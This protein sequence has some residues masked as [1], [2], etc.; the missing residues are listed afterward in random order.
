MEDCAMELRHLRYF[1]A[2][3]DTLHFT[4]A[5]A[6]LHIAQPA[7]SQQIRVLE[8]E[9]GVELFR[10]SSRHTEITDA[11]RVF[12]VEAKR[13]VAQ[14]DRSIEIARRAQRGEIG[15]IV[16]GFEG[17]A[18]YDLLPRI[19]SRFRA[20]YPAVR[21]VL[22]QQGTTE[23]IDALLSGRIDVGL[24]LPDTRSAALSTEVVSREP[25]IAALPL[26]Q[27]LA[28]TARIPISAL[29]TEEFVLFPRDTA[30]L[31]YDQII[32]MCAAAGFSPR[33]AQESVR[34]VTIIGLVAA[35]FGVSIVPRCVG[36][37]RH[38]QVVFRPFTEATP[39]LE[40]A[41]AWHPD[42][43]SAAVNAF[44]AVARRIY[45]TTRSEIAIE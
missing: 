39:F 15:E 7:L 27:P 44:L 24:L 16:I 17:A 4:R 25:F 37:L 21:I 11:G 31:P 33:V 43:R 34:Y 40:R 36:N 38:E 19:L 42:N 6:R 8:R 18:A 22:E 12:L 23:Q 1:I 13:I 10:R 14:A 5:A 32:A 2:V 41:I 20:C 9:V 45:T 35:G 26:G 30:A 28:A 29:A 3:A